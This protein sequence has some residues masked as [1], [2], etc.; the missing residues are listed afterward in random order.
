[1]PA[2][3]LVQ[4]RRLSKRFPCDVE[5]Q[6][7]LLGPKK[8]ETTPVRV[9]DVSKGGVG[10]WLTRW[11]DSG[12]FLAIDLPCEKGN[13]EV[14]PSLVRIQYVVPQGDNWWMVGA[15]FARRHRQEEIKSLL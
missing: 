9:L 10:L 15:A 13:S 6:C 3:S 1:M 14:H 11:Y 2:N 12:T 5:T 8:R 7:R 4:E